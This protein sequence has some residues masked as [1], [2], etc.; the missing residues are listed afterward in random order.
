MDLKKSIVTKDELV[1]EQ[2][3]AI[4]G[5]ELDGSKLSDMPGP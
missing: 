4:I 1:K 3:N 5:K 2:M